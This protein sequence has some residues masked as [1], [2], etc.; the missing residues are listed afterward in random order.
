MLHDYY[1]L[2]FHSLVNVQFTFCQ[3]RMYWS[4]CTSPS[5]CIESHAFLIDSLTC[6]DVYGWTLGGAVAPILFF[7]LSD[8]KNCTISI[9]LLS[10]ACRDRAHRLLGLKGKSFN[11]T[12]CRYTIDSPSSLVP[13]TLCCTVGLFTDYLLISP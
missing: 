1:A 3:M 11:C 7:F 4:C 9:N 13:K 2:L 12:C 6:R 10:L 8:Q 5:S